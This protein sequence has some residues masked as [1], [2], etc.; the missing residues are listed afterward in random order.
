MGD[1]LTRDDMLRCARRRARRSQSSIG[2]RKNRVRAWSCL[3]VSVSGSLSVFCA[4]FWVSLLIDISAS[5]HA[6]TYS[7]THLH[8]VNV[9]HRNQRV[10]DEKDKEKDKDREGKGA[11]KDDA[12]ERERDREKEKEG[13]DGPKDSGVSVSAAGVGKLDKL[14]KPDKSDAKAESKEKE[15]EKEKQRFAGSTRKAQAVSYYFVENINYFG[16]VGWCPC[17]F[18]CCCCFALVSLGASISPLVPFG[19]S[20]VLVFS[21]FAG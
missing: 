3:F 15:K 6:L 8:T 2:S 4:L 17:S 7:P 13:K 1:V 10:M 14:D 12:K 19:L 20:L 5:P 16:R 21:L 18:C 11:E 9:S